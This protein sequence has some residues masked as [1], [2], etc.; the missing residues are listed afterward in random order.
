[1]LSVG[2]L[3]ISG[4]RD[5]HGLLLG[6]SGVGEEQRHHGVVALLAEVDFT[7]VLALGAGHA[8]ARDS[9]VL[10]LV[11]LGEVVLLANHALVVVRVGA[12]DEI[13]GSSFAIL[14]GSA[15]ARG[16]ARHEE[17]AEQA[18]LDII[19]TPEQGAFVIGGG[20]RGGSSHGRTTLEELVHAN[21][22]FAT[23]LH[24]GVEEAETEGSAVAELL[25]FHV[26]FAANHLAS[27][28][29]VVGAQAVNEGALAILE[30]GSVDGHLPG[31]AAASE[32]ANAAV[33]T[34][35]TDTRLEITSH[36]C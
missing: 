35:P 25:V 19:H 24:D 31:R 11:L 13:A 30:L 5:D 29:L 7:S 15:S 22:D 18:D 20:G 12:A 27:V 2:G 17:S 10:P 32:A 26:E 3:T 21:L 1:V 14:D 9:A 33:I 36:C 23:I 8:A 16:Q 6:S 28:V 34:T 4:S